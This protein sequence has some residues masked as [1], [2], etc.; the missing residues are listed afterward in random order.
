M[1][2]G[3]AL[4]VPALLLFTRSFVVAQPAPHSRGFVETNG[5][6]LY[7]EE[8]GSG[9]PVVLIHGGW[10][11]SQQWD[12]QMAL[13]SRDYRVVRYDCRGS[14]R[15]VM[16]D[17]VYAHDDDLSALLA[18]L[19]IDR[20]QIVGV[21]AGA[22]VA[23]DFALSH[24]AM[25]TSLMLGSSPLGG[26]DT[27]QEFR[28]GMRGVA[29]AGVADDLEL[30]QQRIWA[31]APFK[32]ASGM[33]D[34]RKRLDELI[35]HQYTWATNRPTS[36]KSKRGPTPPGARLGEIKIPTLVVV[37]TGEMPGLV[38]EAEFVARTIP[39]AQIERIENAGHFPNLEQPK[40]YD[41]LL[42]NWLR[43]T[44]P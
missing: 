24:P 17:S 28:D 19:H 33:P 29:A 30:E 12:E 7:Y 38:S 27:G 21:S 8:A 41:D 18:H 5:T 4:L 20:A 44:K 11:N 32:V 35:L 13:L 36:P 34:V 14:G 25:V 39:G 2:S 6:K 31:F 26:F 16:G 10:L 37:G 3:R 15:S 1:R 40:R 43:R 9:S 22:Q 23:I 42:T